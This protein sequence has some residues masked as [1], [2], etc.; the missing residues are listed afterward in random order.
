MDN[1]TQMIVD[2]LRRGKENEALNQGGPVVGA[3][4]RGAQL[5]RAVQPRHDGVPIDEIVAKFEQG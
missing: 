4:A 3:G 5:P 1:I 2:I